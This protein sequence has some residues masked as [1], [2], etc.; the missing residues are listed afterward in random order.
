MPGKRLGP[1]PTGVRPTASLWSYP[2]PR[3]KAF[4]ITRA[5]E[6]LAEF[7][8]SPILLLAFRMRTDYGQSRETGSLLVCRPYTQKPTSQRGT[9]ERLPGNLRPNS[10][11]SGWPVTEVLG[12][13]TSA[14]SG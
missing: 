7:K 5:G 6:I 12:A 14:G 3:R 4:K 11:N 9:W 8:L 1:T 13:G 10:P 2:P